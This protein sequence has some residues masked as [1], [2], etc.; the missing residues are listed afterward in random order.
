MSAKASKQMALRYD[1]K[2]TTTEI[3]MKKTIIAAVLITGLSLAS[4]N[5]FAQ[6]PT[7][8]KMVGHDMGQKTTMTTKDMK[9]MPMDE[10]MATMEKRMEN[11]DGMMNSCSK[12]MEHAKK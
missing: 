1:A 7:E 4:S 6:T 5:V 8:A 3:I 9:N 10:R 2:K 11:M 12:M